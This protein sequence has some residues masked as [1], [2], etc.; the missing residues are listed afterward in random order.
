MRTLRNV[1]GPQVGYEGRC[2]RLLT[3]HSLKRLYYSF[4]QETFIGHLL[5]AKTMLGTGDTA[6]VRQM[7]SLSWEEV[8]KFT[9]GRMSKNIPVTRAMK[10]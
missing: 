10:S 6:V 1:L 8:R 9:A 4:T 5:C 7:R 3:T 2:R